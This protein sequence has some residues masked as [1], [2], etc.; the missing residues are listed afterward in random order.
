[1]SSLDNDFDMLLEDLE[2]LVRYEGSDFPP[3]TTNALAHANI[4]ERWGL[5][6]VATEAGTIGYD[7]QRRLGDVAVR[8]ISKAAEHAEYLARR[9]GYKAVDASGKLLTRFK[10]WV[11]E[12]SIHYARKV[13]ELTSK[14]AFLERH[15][16]TLRQRYE[17]LKAVPEGK[18]EV[19]GWVAKICV[20]DTPDVQECIELSNRLGRVEDMVKSYTVRTRK[21][22][23]AELDRGADVAALGRKSTAALRRAAGLFGVINPHGKMDVYPMPG[24]VY[25]AFIGNRIRYAVSRD[26]KLPDE[27]DRLTLHE[28]GEALDAADRYIANLKERG[29]GRKVFGYKGIGDELDSMKSDV[30]NAERGHVVEASIRYKNAVQ[31]EDGTVT[32][33]V[34]TA[35]GLLDY[36]ARSMKE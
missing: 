21:L 29:V 23:T 14:A 35:E 16:D 28:I 12:Y 8:G 9:G 10:D 36:V 19:K 5:P 17:K 1:M 18:I 7:E 15:A 11:H 6:M 32:S 27:L 4:S 33:L 34:R 22:L 2:Q 26:G 3:N 20:D 13:K 31:L 24:N 30:A 25:I